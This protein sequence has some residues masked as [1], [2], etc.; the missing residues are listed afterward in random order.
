MRWVRI[1]DNEQAWEFALAGLLW[2]GDPQ[3]KMHLYAAGV[4]P[5]IWT[6]EQWMD[7][8]FDSTR[9]G[10]LSNYIRVEN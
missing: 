5:S 9:F 4:V 7:T 2:F 1:E 8:R 3:D 10:A 6:K